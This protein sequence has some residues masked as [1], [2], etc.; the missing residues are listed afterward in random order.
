MTRIISNPYV[1]FLLRLRAYW[2]IYIEALSQ[3]YSP[4]RSI[5]VTA[6]I[7]SK[8]K[9]VFGFKMLSKLAVANGKGFTRLSTPSSASAALKTLLQNTVYR[10]LHPQEHKGVRSLYIAITKKCTYNCK[11]CFEYENKNKNEILTTNDYISIVHKYQKY[12]CT[13]ILFSGG[14]PML[15]VDRLCKIA[16]ACDPTSDLWVFTSGL[17]LNEENAQRLKNAGLTGVLISID[18]Y[19]AKQHDDFRGF[20][21]AYEIARNAIE[22]THKAKLATA[23]SICV[24]KEFV[25]D[26]NIRAYMEFAKTLD[27]CFVQIIEARA[28][29]RLIAEDVSL[30][31]SQIRLLE[32]AYLQYNT[33][34]KYKDYPIIEYSGYHQRR[35][36]CF[37]AGNQFFYL[38]ADGY[39]HICP[40]CSEKIANAL[41]LT[42]E[43]LTKKLSEHP[44]QLFQNAPL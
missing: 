4:F 30:S 20:K 23:L 26:E 29:G 35:F 5:I 17:G 25:S 39:A 31:A 19:K 8:H 36:G 6:Q 12:G 18:H 22:N 2:N 33:K 16:S 38:D 7:I 28:R 10:E 37:G 27:V 43:E 42:A 15:S 41:E 21:G 24:T 34:K 44:C 40:F 3:T 32:T 9:K 14:E 13:Q 11:H 1:L